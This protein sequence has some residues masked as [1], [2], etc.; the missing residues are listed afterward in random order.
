MNQ[1]APVSAN[2]QLHPEMPLL[3]LAG[4]LHLRIAFLR[5]ILG[6][7]RR[8]DDRGVHNRARL[9]QQL[10]LL[11]QLADLGEQLRGQLM[12]LQQVAKSQDS[13]LVRH[14]IH[15]QVNARKP[16]HRL[17]VVERIFHRRIGQVEP[18]LHE[19]DA[20]HPRHRVRRTTLHRLRVVRL[21][22]RQQPRPRHHRLHLGEELRSARDFRL[23]RPVGRSQRGLFH[24]HGP[25]V[26][27]KESNH[28][29][30][31]RGCAEFP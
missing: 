23:E 10:L 2:V 13:R 19:V 29:S 1:A 15:R 20:Q 12:L 26:R 21:D 3:A 28:R 4:L 6:R 5:R 14:Q 17:A 16:A 30:D 18:L 11:Q 31:L 27:A 24:I 7:W 25:L 8:R 22:D 9:E